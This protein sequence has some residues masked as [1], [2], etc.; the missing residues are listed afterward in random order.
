LNA[1]TRIEVDYSKQLRHL[2]LVEGEALFVVG[3]DPARPF[4][5]AAGM[6]T[7]QAL[8]TQFN[9]YRHEGGATVSVLEGAVQVSSDRQP[10]RV[11]AGEEANVG[12]NG[13]T[14]KRSAA[15]I[16][17]AVAWRRR[18][19]VFRDD[20]LAKVAAEFNRYNRLQIQVEGAAAQ[21]KQLIGVF[22]ADDPRSLMLFL[23]KDPSL[24][25]ERGDDRIVIKT[26]PP[27]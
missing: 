22:D 27:P 20:P 18:Q 6:A 3:R 5:V 24:V 7:I 2:T 8:G 19:L 11:D 10:V 23:E 16:P 12:G 15:D 17:K 9:V 14:L 4:R 13:P 26:R 25:V 21:A 1:H